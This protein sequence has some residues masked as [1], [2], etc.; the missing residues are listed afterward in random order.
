MKRYIESMVERLKNL[1]SQTRTRLG[2]A[3]ALLLLIIVILSFANQKITVLVK[4]R[5]SRETDLVEM[6]TLKQRYLSVKTDSQ[7]FSNRLSTTRADDSPAKIIEEIGIKGK[8]SQ[9]NPVKGED[10]GEYVEDAAE[11][12]LEGLT[13]NDAVN[14]IYRLEKGTRPVLIKKANIRT[15][16]DDP[17]RLDLTLTIALLKFSQPG[18]R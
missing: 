9:I 2:I 7:R 10:R 5:A 12:K 13:A 6:M 16:F 4:K 11:V 18:R 8:S 14:L 15:R 17:A 1:D 3:V